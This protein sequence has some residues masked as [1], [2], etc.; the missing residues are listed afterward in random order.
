MILSG[1]NDVIDTQRGVGGGRE[2]LV[3]EK[4]ANEICT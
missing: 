2:K 1:W 3:I 4:H